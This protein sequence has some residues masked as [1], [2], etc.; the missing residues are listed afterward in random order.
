MPSLRA[1]VL[2][3]LRTPNKTFAWRA[4]QKLAACRQ[5]VLLGI[6]VSCLL[7]GGCGSSEELAHRGQA[8]DSLSAAN[9]YL[10]ARL[11]VLQDSLQFHDDVRTGRY[12]RE[13][14][15]LRARLD[16]MRYDLATLRDGGR[17]LAVIPA[18][19]LFRPASAV[20][21]SAGRTRLDTLAARLQRLYPARPVRVEGHSDDLPLSGSLK[22]QYPSNWELSAARA[23][24]VVR[25][26]IATHAL[27][28]KRF[29]IAANGATQPVAS[30]ET[31]AGRRRNRRVRIAVLPEL[32]A[33]PRADRAW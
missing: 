3:L 10:R 6:L 21:T 7:W 4:C 15:R 27:T 11:E 30:N 26:L 1:A 22:E 19:A 5:S 25:Y 31:A 23:G 16:R 17:T 12:Y 28:P 20:L 13:R 33:H 9:S 29:T 8:V 14:R 32:H 18:D 2:L 24:A